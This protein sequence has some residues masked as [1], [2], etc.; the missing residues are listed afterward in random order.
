M[1][2]KLPGSVGSWVTI[3]Y[4]NAP[5]GSRTTAPGNPGVGGPAVLLICET[6]PL[7]RSRLKVCITAEPWVGTTTNPFEF[8]V[9]F[10]LHAAR[11]PI[12]ITTRTAAIQVNLVRI[13]YLISL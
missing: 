3:T 6:W 4:A 2:V 9:N 12:A 10:L 1:P 7:L 5:A 13:L 8:A 11:R